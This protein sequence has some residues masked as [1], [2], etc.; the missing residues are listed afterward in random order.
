LQVR[1]SVAWGE[2]GAQGLQWNT[3]RLAPADLNQTAVMP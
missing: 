1:L 3:L 2:G